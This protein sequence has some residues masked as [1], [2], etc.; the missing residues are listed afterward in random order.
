MR[1]ASE[2]RTVRYRFPRSLFYI[3]TFAPAEEGNPEARL[4][5]MK[6]LKKIFSQMTLLAVMLTVALASTIPASAELH[7]RGFVEG[8]LGVTTVTGHNKSKYLERYIQDNGGGAAFGYMLAT[9]HGIQLGKHFIGLGFGIAP[10]YCAVGRSTDTSSYSFDV[11]RLSRLSFPLYA[12]WR[13]DFFKGGEWNPYIGAK[14]GLFPPFGAEPEF[15]YYGPNYPEYWDSGN[16]ANF[17]PVYAAVDFGM[18]KRISSN[19]GISFGL[20]IQTPA[21]AKFRYDDNGKPRYAESQHGI[22]I[23]AKVAFDF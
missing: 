21:N 4:K 15:E 17:F 11:G 22:S 5:D 19:S 13:Y 10:A 3:L 9:T 20:T 1:E 23:L 14:C 8:G 2:S 16:L 18:R 7:Y 6:R 12:N